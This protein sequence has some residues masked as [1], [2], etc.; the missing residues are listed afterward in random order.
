M[1]QRSRV[2]FVQGA[3][4]TYRGSAVSAVRAARARGAE[5]RRRGGC[6]RQDCKRGDKVMKNH[7]HGLWS[8]RL[9]LAVVTGGLALGAASTVVLVTAVVDI[10][11]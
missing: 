5:G 7:E 3:S 8:L 9:G 11:G 6:E 4:S 10:I 2:A 1:P